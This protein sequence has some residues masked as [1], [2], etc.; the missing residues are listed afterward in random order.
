MAMLLLA[1][2]RLMP[3]NP[4]PIWWTPMLG[5]RAGRK[6]SDEHNTP[7]F[8]EVF[9]A[10]DRVIS[11]GLPVGKVATE[12]G[13]NVQR[14]GPRETRTLR[15]R[16]QDSNLRSLLETTSLSNAAVTQHFN[17]TSGNRPRVLAI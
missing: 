15:W 7:V 17:S 2:D 13:L 8:P 10:V 12:L 14:P 6:V 5:F 3:A 1:F 11:S 16:K 4:P 9:E